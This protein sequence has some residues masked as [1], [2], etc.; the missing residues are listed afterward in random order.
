MIPIT[1]EAGISTIAFAFKEPLNGYGDA[2]AEIAM[3][4]TCRHLIIVSFSPK[5]YR[6]LGKT[7]AAAYEL[8]GIFGEANGQSLPLGFIFTT[9]TDGSATV[10]TKQRMLAE[11]LAWLTT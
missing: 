2:T 3:D 8:Y 7:N 6:Y 10:G 4:S 11:A 9:M 5:H 1:P